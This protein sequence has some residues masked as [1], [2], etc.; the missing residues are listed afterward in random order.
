MPFESF[1]PQEPSSVHEKASFE[2]RDSLVQIASQDMARV[3]LVR[4]MSL[5]NHSGVTFV[6]NNGGFKYTPD[7]QQY[8][9][10]GDFAFTGD[11]AFDAA[12]TR[13]YPNHLGD[14]HILSAQENDV[15]EPYPD[16]MPGVVYVKNGAEA[17]VKKIPREI[18]DES[19][20]R[21]YNGQ[22]P[23]KTSDVLKRL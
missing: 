4:V 3:I 6:D 12:V 11:N 7:N 10:Q 19:V 5:D 15:V 18:V 17:D 13:A 21:I 1:T 8:P 2:E 20:N 14:I 23:L 16:D 22:E 9:E